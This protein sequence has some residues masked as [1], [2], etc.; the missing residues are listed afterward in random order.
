MKF[1]LSLFE[2][3]HGRYRFTEVKFSD[4]KTWQDPMPFFFFGIFFLLCPFKNGHLGR[5][6]GCPL[7]AGVNMK[8]SGKSDFLFSLE[9]AS[10]TIGLWYIGKSC[11]G[12]FS[13]F[14]CELSVYIQEVY[15]IRLV[16]IATEVVFL[17]FFSCLWPCV[18]PRIFKTLFLKM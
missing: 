6:E 12:V 18:P 11:F 15:E 7:K 5:S 13:K 2:L 9:L 1:F 4:R 16:A 14:K 17:H 10:S 3:E 8:M